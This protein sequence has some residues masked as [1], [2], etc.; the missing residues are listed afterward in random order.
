MAGRTFHCVHEGTSPNGLPPVRGLIMEYYDWQPG[1]LRTP[2]DWNLTNFTHLEFKNTNTN[3]FLRIVRPPSL[4]QLRHSAT[5]SVSV[6]RSNTPIPKWVSDLYGLETLIKM[7]NA[8]PF[9]CTCCY[10]A[11]V[12][13]THTGDLGGPG[14]VCKAQPRLASKQSRSNTSGTGS[15]SS[16]QALKHRCQHQ[17]RIR[18]QSNL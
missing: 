3:E 16:P 5:D 2:L 10:Q 7:L 9:L 15:S 11:R 1:S 8:E 4:P 6:D 12:H 14:S 18:F 17:L 13:A